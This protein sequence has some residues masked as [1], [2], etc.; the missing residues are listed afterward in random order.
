MS[1]N[2]KPPH[3]HTRILTDSPGKRN[4]KE[5]L[6]NYNKTNRNLCF[7]ENKRKWMDFLL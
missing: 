3:G 1:A 7:H 5:D 4:G 6:T 2:G